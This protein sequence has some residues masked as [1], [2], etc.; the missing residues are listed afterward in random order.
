MATDA[1]KKRALQRTKAVLTVPAKRGKPKKTE[2]EQ[3]VVSE[4]SSKRNEITPLQL[5][6]AQWYARGW[7]SA[8]IARKLQHHLVLHEPDD[9]L[10]LKKARQRIRAWLSTAKMRDAVYAEAQIL[11]DLESPAIMRGV[12]RKAKAGRVDAARLAFEL[13]G[14]HSPHTDV[15]PAAINIVFAGVPRPGVN[16]PQGGEIIDVDADE[17]IEDDGSMA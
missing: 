10:R 13:N 2:L 11:L 8:R 9:E 7:R 1:A 14:R 6:V 17:E 15:Q 5:L 16:R 3:T 4:L 12:A